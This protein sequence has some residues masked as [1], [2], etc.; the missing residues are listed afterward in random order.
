MTDDHRQPYVGAG[1][2]GAR[3]SAQID[4][5]EL[6]TLDRDDPRRPLIE[7]SATRWD[8]QAEELEAAGDRTARLNAIHTGT[9]PPDLNE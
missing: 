2:D 4:R 8:R 9:Y 6:D 1:A 7:E 3:R 5:D